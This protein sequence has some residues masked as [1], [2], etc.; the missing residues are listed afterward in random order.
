MKDVTG[1]LPGSKGL[2]ESKKR[3]FFKIKKKKRFFI[4]KNNVIF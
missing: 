1:F 4:I 3:N 2:L